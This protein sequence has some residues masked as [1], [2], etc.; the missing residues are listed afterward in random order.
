[1]RWGGEM[2]GENDGGRELASGNELEGHIGNISP[3]VLFQG[4]CY[5]LRHPEDHLVLHWRRIWGLPLSRNFCAKIGAT[6]RKEAANIS[7][8]TALLLRAAP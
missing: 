7:L 6:L 8:L 4:L 5:P 1:M 3:D 2:E